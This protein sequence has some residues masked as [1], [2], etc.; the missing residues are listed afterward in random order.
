MLE[1]AE[2]REIA[3]NLYNKKE[4]GVDEICRALGISKPTLYAYISEPKDT[5][6]QNEVAGFIVRR[7]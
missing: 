7:E 4:H 3:I 2:Q 5:L 6:A 1:I